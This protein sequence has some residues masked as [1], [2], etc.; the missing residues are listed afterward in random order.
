M[1]GNGKENAIREKGLIIMSER[2]WQQG[3]YGVKGESKR[4]LKNE[5][6]Q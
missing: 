6:K 2:R 1:N 5:E 3:V 4:Q